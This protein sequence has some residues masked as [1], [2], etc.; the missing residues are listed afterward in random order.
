MS[1]RIAHLDLDWTESHSTSPSGYDYVQY[2]ANLPNIPGHQGPYHVSVLEQRHLPLSDVPY[3]EFVVV[4]D[5]LPDPVGTVSNEDFGIPDSDSAEEM[6]QAV[7]NLS[8]QEIADALTAIGD[9]PLY[10]DDFAASRSASIEHGLKEGKH[11]IRQSTKR[12]AALDLDWK[13]DYEWNEWYANLPAIP[14]YPGT[15]T[16]G[17]AQVAVYSVKDGYCFE[18]IV[19]NAYDLPVTDGD[20]I[21]L[22]NSDFGIPD[23][24]TEDE[25]MDIVEE[26]LTPEMIADALQAKGYMPDDATASRQASKRSA[27][28][29][30]N[31]MEGPQESYTADLPYLPD[32]P[33]SYR[34]N[35]FILVAHNPQ[36]YDVWEFMVCVH[37]PDNQMII[38]GNEEFGIPDGTAD[39]M[40]DAVE[41]LDTDDIERLLAEK[42]YMPDED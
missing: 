16:E 22:Y 31:W 30:L 7:E 40:M 29:D 3:Y 32:Y 14:G 18:I 41:N 10:G 8:P 9:V 20:H 5:G 37:T 12:F 27:H 13:R 24:G 36:N 25:M 21:Y 28:M 35:D 11:M 17:N 19:V 23:T 38:L 2:T 39:E 42:D 4:Y 6:M 1:Q 15:Q 33:D 26:R 34:Y